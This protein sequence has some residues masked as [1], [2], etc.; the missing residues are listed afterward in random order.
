MN[1]DH[2]VSTRKCCEQQVTS[3][4]ILCILTIFI[5]LQLGCGPSFEERQAKKEN[6]R[7]E[8]LQ[9]MNEKENRFIAAT[10]AKYNAVYFPPSGLTNNAFTYELQEFVRLNSDKPLI[11]KGYLDDIERTNKGIVVEF[12][13]PVGKDYFF[14]GK[15]ITFRLGISDNA[16]GP[17]LHKKRQEPY[18]RKI[19]FFQQPEYL[20]IARIQ[21]LATS[22]LFKFKGTSQGEEVEIDCDI[23]KNLLSTGQFIDAVP[24]PK[25]ANQIN[26]PLQR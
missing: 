13:C 14:T 12:V 6:A 17:F 2:L 16:V 20:V 21:E 11:F 9:A 25:N 23:A 4:V 26:L 22:Q 18:L 10:A 3:G 19:R 5:F 24:Y 7:K 15:T 8:Q 1:I